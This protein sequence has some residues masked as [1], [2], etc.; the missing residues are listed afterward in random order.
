MRKFSGCDFVLS[1]TH[2][3]LF[4]PFF[5]L[6]ERATQFFRSTLSLWPHYKSGFTYPSLR[7][8]R[9]VIEISLI[10]IKIKANWAE[11]EPVVAGAGGIFVQ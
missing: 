4:F 9:T 2:S 1:E 10:G 8:L 3:S 6:P 5:F 7:Y 11:T